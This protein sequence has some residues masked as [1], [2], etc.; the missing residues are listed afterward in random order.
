MVAPQEELKL[1]AS[2]RGSPHLQVAWKEAEKEF[3]RGKERV[4]DFPDD[5]LHFFFFFFLN[6]AHVNVYVEI[7]CCYGGPLLFQVAW[8]ELVAILRRTPRWSHRFGIVQ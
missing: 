5:F 6:R 3:E 4:C 2:E 8:L 7:L 1:S